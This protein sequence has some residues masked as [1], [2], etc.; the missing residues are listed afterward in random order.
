MT[1]LL[2]AIA[3][4]DKNLKEQV[5]LLSDAGLQPAEIA[6]ITGKNANLIRV[7]K[8]SLKPKVEKR[9]AEPA[10]GGEQDGPKAI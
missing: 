5:K 1:K 4:R 8:A 3:A 7:T 2:A 9:S 10:V 6:S